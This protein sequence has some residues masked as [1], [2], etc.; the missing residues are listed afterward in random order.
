MP[1]NN[2]RLPCFVIQKLS[3]YLERRVVKNCPFVNPL[4]GLKL[5][6]RMHLCPQAENLEILEFEILSKMIQSFL[7]T[8]NDAV[9]TL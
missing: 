7:T 3:V 8:C 1:A 6:I 4:V 9:N 5:V 2:D